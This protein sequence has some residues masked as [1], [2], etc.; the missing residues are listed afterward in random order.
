MKF[1]LKIYLK[2][3][4]QTKNYHHVKSNVTN[5]WNFEHYEN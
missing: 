1:Y 3:S 2:I 5:F 4:I